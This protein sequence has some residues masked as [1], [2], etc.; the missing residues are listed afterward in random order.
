MAAL[1]LAVLIT[2]LVWLCEYA[3]IMAVLIAA[4]RLRLFLMA[5]RIRHYY[6]CVDCVHNAICYG[7]ML[8]LHTIAARRSS[9]L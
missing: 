3:I 9:D 7:C 2:P 4:V 5:V 8:P 1:I 6:G